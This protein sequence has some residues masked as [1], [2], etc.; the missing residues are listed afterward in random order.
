MGKATMYSNRSNSFARG[1]KIRR[2]SLP[3]QRCTSSIKATT[4][5]VIPHLIFFSLC[6]SLCWE[7]SCAWWLSAPAIFRR[8]KAPVVR[9]PLFEHQQQREETHEQHRSPIK[10]KILSAKHSGVDRLPEPTSQDLAFQAWADRNGIFAPSVECLTT[11]HSV[12]ERGLFVMKSCQ[13][14]Q[15]LASIPHDL[16]L[17]SDHTSEGGDEQGGWAA[18]ITEQIL[19]LDRTTDKRQDWIHR[20]SGGGCICMEDAYNIAGKERLEQDPELL[21]DV[22]LRLARRVET[23]LHLANNYQL[24]EHDFPLYSLVYSRACF[25]GPTWGSPS[26]QAVGIVPLFDMLNHDGQGGENVRLVSVATAFAEMDDGAV[27]PDYLDDKDMLLVATQDLEAGTELLTE[28]LSE[29][30][31]DPL[32]PSRAEIQGRKLVQYGFL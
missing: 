16:I 15:V 12:G 13:K 6:L 31:N 25:L 18:H 19:K 17:W 7:Q 1:R 10:S 26:S 8:H 28:Y 23:W 2:R 14:G 22:Q 27:K 9:Y 30:S 24:H 20:W 5:A 11:Y 21:K 32:A 4:G 3:C 29:K